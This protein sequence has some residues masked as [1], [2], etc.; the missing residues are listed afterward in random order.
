MKTVLTVLMVLLTTATLAAATDPRLGLWTHGGA[1]DPYTL[2]VLF[3]FDEPLEDAMYG[4]AF[5]DGHLWH[6]TNY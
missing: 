4:T 3:E 5:D 6:R 2:D 1:L